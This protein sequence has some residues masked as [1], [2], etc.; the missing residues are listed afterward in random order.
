MKTNLGRTYL[1]VVVEEMV[2]I[3][4]KQQVVKMELEMA[5]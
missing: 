2:I 3:V 5:R 4:V 1:V